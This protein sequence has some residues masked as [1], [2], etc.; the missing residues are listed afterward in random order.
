ML[1]MLVCLPP[2]KTITF[3]LTV[4]LLTPLAQAN[5]LLHCEVTYAGSTQVIETGPVADPYPVQ[6]IDIGGRFWFKP[7]M[8]G[9]GNR[10][11]YVKLY[12]Y[13]DA[14]KQPL[15]LQEAIYR[16]P[17]PAATT[18]HPLTGEQHLYG[19]ALE[20]ELIYSCTLQGVQP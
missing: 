13:L 14:Q 10:V 3:L 5:P 12:A 9:E 11:D 6:S 2:K 18:P 1:G 8:V 16:P 15:L 4:L 19:G 17:F 20:R 7:V